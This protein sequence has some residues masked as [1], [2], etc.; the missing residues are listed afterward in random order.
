MANGTGRRANWAGLPLIATLARL[1]CRELTLQNEYLRLENRVL[2]D[3]FDGRIRFTD[4]ERWVRSVTEECLNH[5]ILFGL[6]SLRRVLGSYRGFFNGLRPHQGIGNQ[7]P[8]R[9][10]EGESLSDRAGDSGASDGLKVECAEF[11][12]GLLKSY[13]VAA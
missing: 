10:V 7:I 6:D 13:S 12:G 8:G 2:R 3:K 5:L 4:E 11:L 9:V 1:L